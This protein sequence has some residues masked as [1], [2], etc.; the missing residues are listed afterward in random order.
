[1]WQDDNQERRVSQRIQEGGGKEN[2]LEKLTLVG[3]S[4]SKENSDIH[5]RVIQM[6]S[7]I[8]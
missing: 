5:L 7:N 1:M 8:D 4:M 6:Y 3:F 2:S